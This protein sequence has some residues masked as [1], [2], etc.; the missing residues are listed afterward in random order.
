MAQPR[1]RTAREA[2]ATA[3]G[4]EAR[5]LHALP[6]GWFGAEAQRELRLWHPALW[7]VHRQVVG[8]AVCPNCKRQTAKQ[9]VEAAR[10]QRRRLEEQAPSALLNIVRELW[11]RSKHRALT[12]TRVVEVICQ[13]RDGSERHGPLPAE[14]ASTFLSLRPYSSPDQNAAVDDGR[15]TIQAAVRVVRAER[16]AARQTAVSA[17]SRSGGR[18]YSQKSIQAMRERAEAKAQPSYWPR[19]PSWT[20]RR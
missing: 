6:Q 12:S 19:D 5:L 7:R 18:G 20:T 13:M 1:S 10:A 17:P 3:S 11:Q 16:I 4:E 15:M 2:A 14:L 8:A 9:Q